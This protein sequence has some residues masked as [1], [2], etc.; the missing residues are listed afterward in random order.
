[1][2]EQTV[3]DGK[4]TIVVAIPCL[5]E[6]RFIGSVVAKAKRYA[7]R[8][9]VIDD[10]STDMSADIAEE[11]GALVH[12][13]GENR[14]YGAAICS[15]LDQGRSLGADILITLDGDGQHDPRDIP[16]LIKPILDGEAD[17]VVGS[18]FLGTAN[19]SPLYRRMGQRV[20]NVA[21]NL[22]S[23]HKISDS[24]SGCRAYSGKALRELTLYERGM[25][26]SSQIQ[27][28]IQESGLRVAEIPIDV[29]YNE[30][31]KRNPMG[32]GI[33]VMTRVLVLYMLKH[34]LMMFGLPGIVSMI[35]ALVFGIRV[36]NTYNSGGYVPLG[37][38]LAAMMFGLVGLVGILAGLGLQAMKELFRGEAYEIKKEMI[39]THLSD[40]GSRQ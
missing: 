8:V 22:G 38:A 18:R 33:N 31:A 30:K 17:V 21:T 23:G 9:V 16:R 34:P 2:N 4:L 14:G 19:R 26:V 25:S 20:L 24:Q 27:F 7:H 28:A 1:M 5:N 39:K 29:V 37:D 13:H 6:E 36:L 32:H 15:A 10:G 3:T 12:R 11:T 40:N 35:I